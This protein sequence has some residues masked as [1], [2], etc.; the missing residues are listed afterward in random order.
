MYMSEETP[1]RLCNKEKT[2]CDT[3][4]G[5]HFQSSAVESSSKDEGVPVQDNPE[6][7]HGNC[8]RKQRLGNEASR[9]RLQK[10]GRRLEIACK[11][12]YLFCL[13]LSFNVAVILQDSLS[14]IILS[15]NPSPIIDNR[16]ALNVC[17]LSTWH[18]YTA[19]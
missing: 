7:P 9:N 2:H 10:L 13:T 14:T 17:I 12:F 4:R 15:C 6:V 18:V 19:T 3:R 16:Y 8:C 5:L 11:R 1:G